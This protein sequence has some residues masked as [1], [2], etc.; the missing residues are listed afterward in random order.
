MS[1]LG[2]AVSMENLA[3]NAYELPVKSTAET[4][5]EANQ[6]GSYSPYT[7]VTVFPCAH[8]VLAEGEAGRV[9]MPLNDM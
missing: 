6:S 3:R 4:G 5:C 1:S 8:P 9:G 7:H 2:L